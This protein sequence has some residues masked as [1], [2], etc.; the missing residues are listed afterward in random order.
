[1]ENKG[2]TGGLPAGK[3][4]VSSAA[5]DKKRHYRTG[6]NRICHKNSITQRPAL[7]PVWVKSP[8]VLSVQG[9]VPRSPVLTKFCV[10][11]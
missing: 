7:V 2:F 9:A 4:Q 11:G 6:Q 3:Q 5:C 10:C 8:L 1:V